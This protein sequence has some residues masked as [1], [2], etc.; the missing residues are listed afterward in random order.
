MQ[1]LSVLVANQI[2]LSYLINNKIPLHGTHKRQILIRTYRMNLQM[3]NTL[4]KTSVGAIN[5]L[6]YE[7]HD[8]IFFH[9]TD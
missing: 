6:D 3:V 2:V 1:V 8:F 9:Q 4:E 5:K 7:P